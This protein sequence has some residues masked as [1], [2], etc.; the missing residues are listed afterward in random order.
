MDE[1]K[2]FIDSQAFFDSHSHMAG[3]D[4]GGPVDDCQPRSLPQILVNDYLLY[5]S[6]SCCDRSVSKDVPAEQAEDHFRAIWPHLEHCRGLATWA[7]YRE[8][9]RELHPFEGDDITQENWATI[10]EKILETYAE[11]GERAWQREVARRAGVIKQAHMCQ[12]SYVV[13]HWGSLPQA[14]RKAQAQLLVPCL[15]LDG[16]L[17]SGF[18]VCHQGRL[19]SM[20]ILGLEPQ[21]YSEYLE[22]CEMALDRFLMEGG[23]ALKLEAAYHRTLYFEQVSDEEGE[24]LFTRGAESLQGEQLRRL[25]DNLLWH[26]MRMAR[27]RELPLLVHTGYSLPSAWGDPENMHNLARSGIKMGLCHSGWPHEGGALLMCRTYRTCYFDMCWTPLLSPTLGRQILAAAIDMVPMNKIIIGTDC[28]SAECFYGTV[29]L[30]RQVLYEVLSE[31]IRQRQ[32]GLPVAQSIARAILH[33]NACEFF[34]YPKN[35]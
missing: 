32:F 17:F 8:A 23:K 16:Y 30:I 29:K 1:L 34:G 24:E 10:N 11:H 3:F 18:E 5:L 28:G 22:F 31:K 14:E 9:I 19:R 12:L 35:L 6:G 33:D 7:V 13:D 25:Q 20:E 27:E 21:S 15:I 26:F 2:A 4:V